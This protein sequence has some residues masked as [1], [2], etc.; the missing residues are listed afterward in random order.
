MTLSVTS[1]PS[2]LAALQAL[3][4]QGAANPADSGTR[5]AAGTTFSK[6][7]SFVRD[8][9][10]TTAAQSQTQ[11]LY[12]LADGAGQ[13]STAADAADA[14]GQGVLGLL[15]QLRDAAGASA[16][17]ST[18]S[19]ARAALQAQFQ[20]NAGQIAP[21]LAGATVNGVNLLDGSLSGGLKVA[22]SDGTTASLTPV[23]LSLGGSVLALTSD[24]SVATATAAASAFA[25]LGEAIGTAGSALSTLRS[26][27][28]Q[29]S[30]HSSFVQTLGQAVAS[31]SDDGGDSARLL[32]L[33]VSQQLSGLSSSVANASPQSILSLFRS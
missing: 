26:Q 14:A 1:A 23:D 11:S 13:A 31:P 8:A 28:D 7:A 30:A 25:S 27:A 15:Q 10:P 17:P 3:P 33:H 29:I 9:A 21:T 22:L 18:S 2:A 5:T 20:A 4:L 12:A 16:S 6:S 32:A 19:D 24:A